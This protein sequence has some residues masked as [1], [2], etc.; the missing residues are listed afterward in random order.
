MHSHAAAAQLWG[1][2]LELSLPDDERRP[3]LLLE[4]GEALAI[5]DEPAAQVLDEAARA[6]LE[7]GDRLSAAEAESTSGWLLSLAG[8]PEQARAHDRRALALVHDAAPSAAK[9]L[10]LAR[11][12]THQVVGHETRAE[13]LHLLGEALSIAKELGLR[14][15]QAEALQFVGMIRLDAGD[16]R[17][18]EDNASSRYRDRGQ[19]TGLAELLRKPR[20]HAPVR[21]LARRVCA[22][23]RR[24]KARGRALRHSHSGQAVPRR[25]GRRPL[26]QR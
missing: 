19:L 20:R 18:V 15:M 5:A 2:A 8:R 14:E 7:A 3:R 22:A 13:A 24:G 17:G 6:L 11:A 12:G 26:L 1:Q 23:P 4:Y 25:A 10:I 21:R 16:E 9:A